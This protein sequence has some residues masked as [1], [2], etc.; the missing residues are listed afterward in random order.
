[1]PLLHQATHE[2]SQALSQA[3]QAAE[4]LMY[5]A[6]IFYEI[7]AYKLAHRQPAKAEMKQGSAVFQRL[8]A[9]SQNY[10]RALAMRAGFLVFDSRE[11]QDRAQRTA[12]LFQA[13]TY[14]QQAFQ[15]NPLLRNRYGPL[16]A[17]AASQ[18]DTQTR[19]HAP[20]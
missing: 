4:W 5:T 7:V 9:M 8:M 10:P 17:E 15:E 13:Q 11:Q 16:A 2:A 14:F 18:L 3:D 1:L 20:Q 6:S 19:P 12:S